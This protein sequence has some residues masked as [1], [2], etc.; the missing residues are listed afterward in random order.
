MGCGGRS[1]EIGVLLPRSIT[2]LTDP[3][4]RKRTRPASLIVATDV[5]VT[6][7]RTP[8]RAVSQGWHIGALLA[9]YATASWR[10]SPGRTCAA[11]SE[12]RDE[13]MPATIRTG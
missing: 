8:V 7:H 2:T 1:G 9:T 11:P 12:I 3:S 6:P 4:A 13:E 5:S 10:V